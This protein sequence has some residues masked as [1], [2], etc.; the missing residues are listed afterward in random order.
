[1]MDV[2]LSILA[3]VAGGVTLELFTAPRSGSAKSNERWLRLGP[4]SQERDEA[5]SGNPS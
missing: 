3:L 5:Q 4:D 2:A 1:M